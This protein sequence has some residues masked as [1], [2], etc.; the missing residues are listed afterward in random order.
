MRKYVGLVTALV[1]FSFVA[2]AGNQSTKK[3]PGVVG[4]GSAGGGSQCDF[5]GNLVA[6]CGFETGVFAP[7]WTQSG[8]LSFTDVDPGSAHSGNFGARLGP[9][10]DQG[11]LS[12]T[13]PTTA[14]GTYT[15]TLWLAHD[16]GLDNNFYVF[17]DGALIDGFVESDAF[18][19]QQLTYDGLV[20]SQDGTDLTFSFLQVP[21]YYHLDDI[22]VVPSSQ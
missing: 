11:Y 13:L 18:P 22:V 6:N 2:F 16:G 8:D 14:G 7:E 17:W 1:C 12:Q 4:N 9:T 10:G 3:N 21:A 19:Y 5:K 15:L 20:A